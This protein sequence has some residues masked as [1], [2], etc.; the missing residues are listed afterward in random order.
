MTRGREMTQ[1]PTKGTNERTNK[2]TKWA[3]REATTRQEVKTRREG[4]EAADDF[5]GFICWGEQLCR[6]P[7]DIGISST[8]D[9][10]LSVHGTSMSENRDTKVY[11]HTRNHVAK[12]ALSG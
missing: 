6:S 5:L 12:F 1:Q 3:R 4:M 2:Q 10:I 7:F 8:L 11:R 9:Q